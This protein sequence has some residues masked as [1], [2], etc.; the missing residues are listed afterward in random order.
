V[1]GQETTSKAPLSGYRLWS[2]IAGDLRVIAA[3]VTT[4]AGRTPCCA[5]VSHPSAPPLVGGLLA[6]AVQGDLAQKSAG[7]TPTLVRPQPTT[8]PAPTTTSTGPRT[9]ASHAPKAAGL[10]VSGMGL[11]A[12]AALVA[13]FGRRGRPGGATSSD[14]LAPGVPE[15]EATPPVPHLSLLRIEVADAPE[16]RRILPPT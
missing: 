15:T 9:D 6:D 13:W 7:T 8:A 14:E 4:V 2:R 16:E 11:A 5:A 1:L 3:P 12:L 10:V